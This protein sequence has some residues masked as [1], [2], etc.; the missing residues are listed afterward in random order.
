MLRVPWRRGVS[1]QEVKRLTDL[2]AG[3]AGC[4]GHSHSQPIAI[5]DEQPSQ[6]AMPRLQ[7]PLSFPWVWSKGPG[8]ED[9]GCCNSN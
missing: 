6:V 3:S 7:H 4:C 9:R 1:H 5:L 8:D 2:T